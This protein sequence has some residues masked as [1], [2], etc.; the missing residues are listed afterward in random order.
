MRLSFLAE[1]H[2]DFIH[3]NY[4]KNE[5][6]ATRMICTQGPLDNTQLDFWRMCFQ[7]HVRLIV[8]LCECT[9]TNKPKC[10]PYWPTTK[11]QKLEFGPIT[12]TN[13]NAHS[14]GD[15]HTA[16]LAVRYENATRFIEHRQW[17]T[18]PDKSIPPSSHFAFKLC[19]C[20]KKT[21]TGPVVIHCSA[22]VGRTGA[23]ALLEIAHQ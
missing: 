9:E 16:R 20:I 21:G 1:E 22:G 15:I 2:G 8:M 14:D 7:E 6:L 13:L 12:V 19:A 17:V 18:W 4:I 23:L 3:A 11:G 10:A 5:N